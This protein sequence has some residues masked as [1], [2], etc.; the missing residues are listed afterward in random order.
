MSDRTELFVTDYPGRADDLAGIAARLRA[1]GSVFA[2][3]EASILAS[4][5]TDRADLASMVERRIA[6]EPVEAIVGW[7][8]FC[9][10]RIV[11]VPGVFVPR[12][13]TELL[14]REAVAIVRYENAPI[15]PLEGRFRGGLSGQAPVVV[16]LCC[17]SGAVGA[18][19]LAG[20][21]TSA[22][23]LEVHVADVDPAA[24]ACARQNIGGRGQIHTGDLY[25]ALPADL[26]GRID[27]LVANAPYV[28][29][30]EIAMMPPEARDHEP[31]AALDGGADGLDVQRRIIERAREWLAPGGHLLVETSRRQAAGTVAAC[32]AAGLATR[33]VTDDDLD[34]TA[35][36]AVAP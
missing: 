29:T 22:D 5:A 2:E 23:E 12:R 8:S 31:R 33:I 6:G 13:R 14:R 24:T 20:V 9:G 30:G 16:E 19:I 26:R 35:V 21:G 7:V 10:L 32:H 34:A 3:E 1:A 15:R 18:A 28:P 11:V 4:A 17:G 25:D 36:V 27:V